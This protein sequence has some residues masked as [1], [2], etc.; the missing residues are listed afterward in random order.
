VKT[1][2]VRIDTYNA[3][4]VPTT[5]GLK[6]A[7]QLAAMKANFAAAAGQLAMIETKIQALCNHDDIKPIQIPFYLN[8]ARELWGMKRRGI[9]GPALLGRGTECHARYVSYG[10]ATATVKRIALD[11]FNLTIP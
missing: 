4:Y 10:L 3:N 8:F 7:A 2:G 6:V 1:S 11:V 9:S 5:V